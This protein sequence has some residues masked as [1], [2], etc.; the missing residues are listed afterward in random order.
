MV[1]PRRAP[2]DSPR[3]GGRPT[4]RGL[5]GGAPMSNAPGAARSSRPLAPVRGLAGAPRLSL[6]KPAGALAGPRSFRGLG[7]RPISMPPGR[8]GRRR[9]GGGPRAVGRRLRLAAAPGGPHLDV[10]PGAEYVRGIEA[11]AFGPSPAAGRG[12]RLTR[13]AG[14]MDLLLGGSSH[15]AAPGRNPPRRNQ[16]ANHQRPTRA[17]HS[18]SRQRREPLGSAASRCTTTQRSARH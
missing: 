13:S 10:R 3:I 17:A 8:L 15:H 16:T 4:W 1:F 12:R 9:P 11:S 6:S 7:Q 2:A 5:G 18:P 14:T